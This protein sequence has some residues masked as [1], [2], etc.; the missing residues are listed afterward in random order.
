MRFWWELILGISLAAFLS[1]CQDTTPVPISD[2][3][4]PSGM[5]VPAQI[6]T[7]GV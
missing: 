5:A 6:H 2:S 4:A 3:A 1:G 7:Q